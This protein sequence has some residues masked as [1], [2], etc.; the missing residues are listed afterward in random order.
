MYR[1]LKTGENQIKLHALAIMVGARGRGKSFFVSNLPK[2]LNFDKIFIIFPTFEGNF[3]QF[4]HL[5]IDP[6]DIFDPDDPLEA[7]KTWLWEMLNE[8]TSLNTEENNRFW[9]S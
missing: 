2:W 4:K 5:N 3:S 1:D 8:T 6:E 9:K 7:E